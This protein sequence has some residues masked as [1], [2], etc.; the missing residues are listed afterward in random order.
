MPGPFGSLTNIQRQ[1]SAKQPFRGEYLFGQNV[2]FVLDTDKAQLGFIE[3]TRSKAWTEVYNNSKGLVAML[4][5]HCFDPDTRQQFTAETLYR[6]LE[7]TGYSRFKDLEGA[8]SYICFNPKKNQ[9]TLTNDRFSILPIYWYRDNNRFCFT[10]N[11]RYFPKDIYSGEP[12]PTSI[13]HFLSIGRYP[14]SHTPLKGVSMLAPATTLK[15]Q[16]DTFEMSFEHYWEFEYKQE[17][18]IN[19]K[20]L[21]H[22]L[23]EAIEKTVLLYTEASANRHGIFLSGGWDSRSILGAT[24]AVN[25]P[26]VSCITN[27]ASD[28]TPGSDTWLAQTICKSIKVPC[29]FSKRDTTPGENFWKHGLFLSEAASEYSPFVF[30]I[31]QLPPHQFDNMDYIL[32]GDVV[33]GGSGE[34]TDNEEGVI[35]KNFPYPLEPNVLSVLTS[36]LRKD[37]ADLYSNAIH[38]ELER[39]PNE[40]P[41]DRQHWLWQMTAI[42]RYVFALGYFDEEFIQVRRPLVSKTVLDQWCRAPEHLRIHKNLFIETLYRRYRNLFNF[43][44]NHTSHLANYYAI[45][46]PYI[47]EKTLECLHNGFDLGGLIDRDECINRIEN[48]KPIARQQPLPGFKTKVRNRIKDQYG[49]RWHRSTRYQENPVKQVHT[50]ND[51]LVFRL[52]MLIEWF[53]RGRNL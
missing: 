47:R 40:R 30:G 20:E 16:L 26:P 31:Y 10:P 2:K 32:K 27:G 15:V 5:G 1:Y 17:Q 11:L 23:G 18:G 19:P 4:H 9:F 38:K 51:A 49:W 35:N 8:F 34:N 45:M 28:Q 39:C 46:S 52:Y 25:R 53:Y 36:G 21:A 3:R 29:Y 50:D 43:G 33:W 44:R 13:I 41:A 14:G 48:F 6:E 7:S 12:D 37:A 24:L 22:D 42:N